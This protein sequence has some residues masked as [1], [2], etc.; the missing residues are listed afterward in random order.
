MVK[1]KIWDE[2]LHINQIVIHINLKKITYHFVMKFL[3]NKFINI[4]THI[5]NKIGKSSQN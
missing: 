1:Q 4:H 2:H 5:L 3:K